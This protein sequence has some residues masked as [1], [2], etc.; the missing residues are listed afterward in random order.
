M[1]IL[2][3]K[4]DVIDINGGEECVDKF[5]VFMPVGLDVVIDRG[6]QEERTAVHSKGHSGESQRHYISVVRPLGCLGSIGI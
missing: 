6:V 5:W 3:S 2:S 4:A 1:L